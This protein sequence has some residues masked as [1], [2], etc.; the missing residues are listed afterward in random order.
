MVPTVN[1][2][3]YGNFSNP[4]FAVFK[5]PNIELSR[6][7]VTDEILR[8]VDRDGKLTYTH[9]R[10]LFHYIASDMIT[11]LCITDEVLMRGFEEGSL[12][13]DLG[14]CLVCY[15]LSFFFKYLHYQKLD[16]M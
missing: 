13:Q 6:P 1:Y 15:I 14:V 8:K 5:V 11:Y 16:N 7:Q 3:Q 4:S 10:Y 12:V 9:D 2:I